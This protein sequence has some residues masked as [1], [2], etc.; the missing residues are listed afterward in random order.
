MAFYSR[1]YTAASPQPVNQRV[2]LCYAYEDKNAFAQPLARGLKHYAE[3]IKISELVMSPKDSLVDKISS[4]TRDN[5][6]VVVL[7]TP[8]SIVAGWVKDEPVREL[9]DFQE[10][11]ELRI[12][13]AIF[14]DCTVPAD[15][16]EFF[17][18]DFRKYFD[19]GLKEL[20]R[21]FSI[22]SQLLS[23]AEAKKL[24]LNMLSPKDREQ[25]KKYVLVPDNS[26]EKANKEIKQKKLKYLILG[27]LLW[28]Y[29]LTWHPLVLI[30]IFGGMAA[31]IFPKS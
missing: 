24:L 15:L 22:N 9:C 14:G 12:I 1:Q 29:F 11:D 23:E 10:D 4:H 21:T 26:R 30:P 7:L 31:L 27:V 17:Y 18:V 20:L 19:F 13:P 25:V 6:Y 5:E 8:G 3:D 28:L 2:T 16:K